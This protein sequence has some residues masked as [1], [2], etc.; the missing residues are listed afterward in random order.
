VVAAYP[1]SDSVIFPETSIAPKEAGQAYSVMDRVNQALLLPSTSNFRGLFRKGSS[2]RIPPGSIIS[3]E[4]HSGGATPATSNSTSAFAGVLMAVKRRHWGVD[5]AFTVRANVGKPG[6]GTEI[7][8][9]VNSPWIKDI[10]VLRRDDSKRCVTL[11]SYATVR[12][13]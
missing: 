9:D 1:F 10:K 5:D 3:V 2:A 8:F 7:R 13:C 11:A 6:V 4:T 12:W